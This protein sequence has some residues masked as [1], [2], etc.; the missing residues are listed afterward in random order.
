[1][2]SSAG[3]PR[4]TAVWLVVLGTLIVTLMGGVGWV[5]W[6]QSVL[7]SQASLVGGDNMMHFLYQADNEYLRLRESWPRPG[8]A[9]PGDAQH[10]SAMEALSL[11]YEI[12]VS[13]IAVL[14]N[15]LRRHDLR[16]E[17]VVMDAISRAEGFI[18]RAD[19]V[20]D[21]GAPLPAWADLV[22]LSADL[23]ALGTSMR[24]LSRSASSLINVYG[25][26]VSEAG[27]AHNRLGIG[28][29]V[30]LALLALAFAG[31]SLRQLSRLQHRRLE[32]ERLTDQLAAARQAAEAAAQ[33]KGAF[34]ANMSHEI[35]TPF[36]GL[37]GMLRLL[38]DTQLDERQQSY[39]RTA[40]TSADHLLT[41]LNDV[42]DMSRLESGQLTLAPVPIRL[43]TLIEDIE[44]LMRPQA[45]SKSLILSIT[46]D[47]SLPSH[48]LCD[49]TRV[50]Q[51]IFN[52]MS[53]AIKFTDRGEVRVDLQSCASGE[54]AQGLCLTVTDTGI[55]MDEAMV[56]RL[57]QRFSQ[58][59][60]SRARRFGGA[61]LGLEISRNLARLMG[62]DI[63]V[64]SEL[65]AGSTFRFT[66][67]LQV[68]PESDAPL[69]AQPP[70]GALPPSE[71][72][73]RPAADV[74]PN[75]SLQADTTTKALQSDSLA[76]NILVA[77]DNE[78]NRLVMEATLGHLGHGSVFA[79]DGRQALS[80]AAS[81]DWDLILM[82]L[83][84]P[85]MDGLD[86]SRAIRALPDPARAG[87][88]IVALTAD[89]F[90]ETRQQ[91]IEA[92]MDGFMTKPIDQTALATLL[93]EIVAAKR[94]VPGG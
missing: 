82:D 79:E 65:G 67:P 89:V 75:L 8:L 18:A 38:G 54:C 33:A 12:F 42:L 77:D 73:L 29:T 72:V 16:E 2:S 76:L 71:P 22:V 28:M 93:A 48:V 7:M 74:P 86:A 30:L 83:H 81:R 60:H 41:L 87:A 69:P 24:E 9:A 46:F 4:R 14:R 36:Q 59:D 57:F 47:D 39:L 90:P 31:F 51:V 1:M 40:S 84:M 27:R 45:E 15:A 64:T 58:G 56:T 25:T 21:P 6:R 63:E 23:D 53:N 94:S 80:M 92:G 19:P 17:T 32:L 10:T 85:E 37:Q 11:R 43:R 26:R 61:G 44:A 70:V 35:R 66:M 13:R 3:G 62:G 20:F 88:K 50:R 91:V 5:Q 68:L 52:L 49:V 78:I 55:G 34:L